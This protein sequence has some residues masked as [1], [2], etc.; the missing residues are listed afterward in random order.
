MK[1]LAEKFSANLASDSNLQ[2]KFD[3]LN[4]KFQRASKRSKKVTKEKWQKL[5]KNVLKFS[6]L[7]PKK[8]PA[9]TQEKKPKSALKGKRQE[10]AAKKVE[11]K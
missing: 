6:Q 11:A 7:L 3:K 9:K 5:N 1:F 10:K 4:D 8:N 2:S